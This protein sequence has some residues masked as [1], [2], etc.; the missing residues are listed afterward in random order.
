MK[1]MD[2]ESTVVRT[3]YKEKMVNW[4]QLK[5]KKLLRKVINPIREKR[6]PVTGLPGCGTDRR[7]ICSLSRHFRCLSRH[8][9]HERYKLETQRCP[10]PLQNE[11]SGEE[12]I[13]Q[14]NM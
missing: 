13:L 2:L 3:L 9:R 4:I 6:I 5:L 8:L 10:H 14:G 11:E 12:S 1:D 7:R